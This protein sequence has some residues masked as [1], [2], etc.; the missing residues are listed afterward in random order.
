MVS[1]VRVSLILTLLA[2]AIGFY[3][4]MY[5][6]TYPKVTEAVTRPPAQ[7]Q[8]SRRRT[9]CCR[10][11]VR[12]GRWWRGPPGADGRGGPLIVLRGPGALAGGLLRP[13]AV[14]ARARGGA[15]RVQARG[16]GRETAG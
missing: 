8:V 7:Q 15:V 11:P 10:R 9:C 12:H 13:C 14:H 4:C 16:N 1:L 5:L 3:V 2:S 6:W